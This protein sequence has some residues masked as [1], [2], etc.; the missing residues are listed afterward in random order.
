MIFKCSLGR[1]FIP[2]L[3]RSLD[4]YKL[5]S[6]LMVCINF[7]WEKFEFHIDPGFCFCN[8]IYAIFDWLPLIF[9]F[10]KNL[11]GLCFL[12]PAPSLHLDNPGLEKN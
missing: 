4:P 12:Y 7:P 9:S 5:D 10:C 6:V 8:K 11:S 1:G 3:N 2:L